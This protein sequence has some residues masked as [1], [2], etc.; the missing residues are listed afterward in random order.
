MSDAVLI[1]EQA[2]S[3]ARFNADDTVSD[4]GDWLLEYHAIRRKA[5]LLT[6]PHLG[7]LSA[8]GRDAVPFLHNLLS[9]DLWPLSNGAP[10]VHACALNSTGHLLADIT[11]VAHPDHLLLVV[12]L[13]RLSKIQQYLNDFL[14]TE[15]VEIGDES[16]NWTIISVQGPLS[17]QVIT[18]LNDLSAVQAFPMDRTGSGGTDLLV[19]SDRAAELWRA[20]TKVGIQSVGC[21]AYHALR[22]EAGIPLYGL[23]MDESILPIEAGLGETHISYKKGCYIGQE[24]IARIRARGHTNRAITVLSIEGDRAPE[25]RDPIIAAA[26][27]DHPVGWVTSVSESP[28]LNSLIALGYVRHENRTNG[29]HLF[30]KSKGVSIGATIIEAPVRRC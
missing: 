6:L 21:K 18:E 15:D 24:V 9:N 16:D 5:G 4:Y 12:P 26:T 23:D 13:S 19:A 1:K 14:I 22:I 28:I 20:L 7:Y 8:F 30:I 11:V 29:N 27:T 17:K 10:Y 2:I 3:G 25:H